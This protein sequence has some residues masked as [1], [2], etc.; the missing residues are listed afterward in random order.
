M[1]VI[2]RKNAR[3]A[4]LQNGIFA[5]FPASS[6]SLPRQVTFAWAKPGNQFSKLDFAI[7]NF[8]NPRVMGDDPVGENRQIK[9]PTAGTA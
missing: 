8:G 7:R 3:D 1:G 4:S 9:R 5:C 6:V 2:L